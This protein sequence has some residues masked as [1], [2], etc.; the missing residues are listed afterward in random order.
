MQDLILAIYSRPET[1][2]GMGQLEQ[3]IP[4]V[5]SDSL[6]NKLRY[7]AKTGKLIRARHGIYAKPNF[8]P[9]ELANKI[10]SPSYVSLETILLREGITFQLYV[11]EFFLLSYLSREVKVGQYT[12]HYRQVK[13]SILT[14]PRGIV[15]KVGYFEATKE[16]A[17]LD[18]VYIYKNYYFDNLGGLDWEKVREMATLYESKTME[19]RVESYYK[20][21]KEEWDVER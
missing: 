11:T 12:F 8:N 7:L 20:N 16:R 9:L 10:Y 1:V 2:F 17:F 14:N 4:G 15:R 21:Y 19:K 18:A 13:K 3:M 5:S 6:R